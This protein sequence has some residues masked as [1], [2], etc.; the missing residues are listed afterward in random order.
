MIHII[1]D[2][3]SSNPP[4]EVNKLGVFYLPQSV[5]SGDNI[6]RDDTDMYF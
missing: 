3:I 2:T 1:A 6:F 4:A 5:F